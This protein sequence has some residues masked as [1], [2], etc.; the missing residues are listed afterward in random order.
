MFGGQEGEDTTLKSQRG[1]DRA[2]EEMFCS[3]AP[4]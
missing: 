3:H 2:G 4:S 1:M